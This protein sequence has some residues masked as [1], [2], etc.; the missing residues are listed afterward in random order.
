[1]NELQQQIEA[2]AQR[3]STADAERDVQMALL[4]KMIGQLERRIDKL[5]NSK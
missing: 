3:L 2:L 4:E 1:M 5:E